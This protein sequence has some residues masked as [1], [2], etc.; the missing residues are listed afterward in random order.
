MSTTAR[1]TEPD[2][3]VID[4]SRVPRVPQRLDPEPQQWLTEDERAKIHLVA[5]GSGKRRPIGIALELKLTMEQS[6]WIRRECSRTGQD[7][8]T[9][10]TGLIEQA[11]TNP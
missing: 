5:R 11:R 6:E 7:Y 8:I 3:E 4:A 10:V 9:F 1:A 2:I